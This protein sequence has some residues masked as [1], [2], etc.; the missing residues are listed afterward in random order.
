MDSKE[1]LEHKSTQTVMQWIAY[2]MRNFFQVYTF[3]WSN[4]W[5]VKTQDSISKSELNDY[6]LFEKFHP[7]W[8]IL[9]LLK[10]IEVVTDPC[11]K[12][13]NHFISGTGNAIIIIMLD[14][15]SLHPFINV[16]VMGVFI[17]DNEIFS[18]GEV[19]SCVICSTYCQCQLNKY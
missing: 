5:Y 7:I 17:L 11:H 3:K 8:L 2:T 15:I 10:S 1:K 12:L 18:E 4:L 14:S 16:T 13:S 6:F 19:P 9:I